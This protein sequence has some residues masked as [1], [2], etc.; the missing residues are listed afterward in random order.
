[1]FLNSK[2]IQPGELRNDELRAAHGDRIS[3]ITIILCPIWLSI[4]PKFEKNRD[5]TLFSNEL[6][7]DIKLVVA[8]VNL[9]L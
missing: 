2:L 5:S 1:M 4:V 7:Q 3:C 9:S 8:F 6:P